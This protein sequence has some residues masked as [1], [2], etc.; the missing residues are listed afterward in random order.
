M[1]QQE[2]R[3]RTFNR[4]AGFYPK[5]LDLESGKSCTFHLFPGSVFLDRDRY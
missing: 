3:D 2:T 4:A 1:S 5:V